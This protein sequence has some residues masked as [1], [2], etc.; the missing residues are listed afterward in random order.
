MLQAEE[1]EQIL[2]ETQTATTTQAAAETAELLLSQIHQ[3]IHRPIIIPFVVAEEEEHPPYLA[4]AD[5][6][7][8]VEAAQVLS[9]ARQDH[10]PQDQPILV[11]GEE[12]DITEM[13]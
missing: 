7:E 10:Q 5:L 8:P 4:V 13:Y 12:E 11:A 6:V 9:T 2:P 1:E 3:P